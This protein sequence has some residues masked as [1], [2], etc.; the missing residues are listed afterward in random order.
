MDKK[1]TTRKPKPEQVAARMA[2]IKGLKM[3]LEG[4]Y[5]GADRQL[6]KAKRL[7][8]KAHTTTNC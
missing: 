3:V 7:L 8:A 1:S 6:A 5:R 4:Q 2:I